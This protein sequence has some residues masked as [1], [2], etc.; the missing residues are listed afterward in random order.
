MV[1]RWAARYACNNYNC[2]ASVTTMIKHLYWRSLRQRRTDICLVI[3]YKTLHGTIALDLFPQLIPLVRPSRHT[4]SEAFQLPAITKQF[5]QYSF[6]PRKIAN[7]NNLPPTA[8]TS[9]SLEIFRQK[10]S[11]LQYLLILHFSRYQLFLSSCCSSTR[12]LSYFLFL[13]NILLLYLT[14]L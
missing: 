9:P 6:L 5:I 2:E 4:H 10:I 13:P 3:F 1:Q 8:A 7:W 14:A 11:S 12:T